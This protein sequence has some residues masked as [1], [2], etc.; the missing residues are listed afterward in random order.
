MDDY[1]ND[2]DLF[3]FNSFL[4][5][6]EGRTY[7]EI[8]DSLPSIDDM[9]QGNVYYAILFKRNPSSVVG[10]WVALIKFSDS[11]FEFF[12]CLGQPVPQP[13]L[14]RLEEYGLEKGLTPQLH[15]TSRSLMAKDGIIC[16]H[17]VMFRLLTLPKT[18]AQFQG[19]FSKLIPKRSKISND[20]VVRFVIN[21]PYATKKISR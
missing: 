1:I 14:D 3:R 9:F 11:T 5:G 6:P 4:K 16:G 7:Y 13:V 19:F 8:G 15:R 12:D 10:H 21:I 18:L 20:D 17:W 2:A